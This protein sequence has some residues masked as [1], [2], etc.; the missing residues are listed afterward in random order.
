[1]QRDGHHQFDEPSEGERQEDDR[2]GTN[3]FD[4]KRLR[5]SQS[6]SKGAD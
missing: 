6:F 3:P 1:M 2:S 5:L 4:P